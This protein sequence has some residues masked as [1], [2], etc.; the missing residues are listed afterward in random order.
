M[1]FA[2]PP[3]QAPTTAARQ[4]SNAVDRATSRRL[5]RSGKKPSVGGRG[6]TAPPWRPPCGSFA[7]DCQTT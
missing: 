6:L 3:N 4:R 5:H 7:V 1:R 2:V